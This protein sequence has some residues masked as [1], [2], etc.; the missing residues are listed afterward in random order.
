M[1][2][3]KC[4]INGVSYGDFQGTQSFATD[5]AL[6]LTPRSSFWKGRRKSKSI[7]GTLLP[8][9][10]RIDDKDLTQQLHNH[11]RNESAVQFFTNLAINSAV[12]PI[13]DI[14]SN[15][16]TYSAISPDEQALVCAAKHFGIVLLRHNTT[17]VTLRLFG[18]EVSYEV[19]NMF[20]F[21]SERKK[22][23]ILCRLR[24]NKIMLFCKGA[25]SVILP[26]LRSP[27]STSQTFVQSLMHMSNYCAEGLRVLCIA[28]RE[29]TEEFYE[30]WSTKYNMA[31]I[32][33]G[34]S[35]EELEAVINE[36][37]NDLELV[38]I[39][40]NYGRYYITRMISY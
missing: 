5:S 16:L 23:S 11:P 7:T 22:S 3:R 24:D 19:L 27:S 14:S 30:T 6:P 20:E 28:Q 32:S 39:S 1:E 37:E 36:I 15:E 40:G 12:V 10:V 4:S 25:D 21:T 18:Q 26:A 35:E 29:I 38:G 34:T 31:K 33:S 13:T 2:F 8:T 9:H 17:S